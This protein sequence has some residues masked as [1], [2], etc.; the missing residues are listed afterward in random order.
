MKVVVLAGG[1]GG[2]KLAAG[3]AAELAP[4]RVT[5]I[6]NTGDDEEFWGLLVCP[7]VDAVIYRLAGV[8]NEAAGYGQKDETFE[9]LNALARLGEPAWFRIGDRDFATHLLR[10]RL[11]ASGATLT[12]TTLELG[13]RFGVESRVV[14]MTDGRVR[15]RFLTAKGNFS[16]QEYFVRERLQPALEAIAFEGLEAARPSPAAVAALDEADLV[17]IGPSNPLISIDPIVHVVRQVLRRERTIVVSPIVGGSALKGPTVEMMRAVGLEP[18][19]LEVARRYRD[20]ASVF[21]LDEVDR[22]LEPQ[23][24]NLGYEV[25]LART[26][27]D[28]GGRR[29][30]ATLVRSGVR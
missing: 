22:A 19:P 18:S 15:T 23:I 12:E 27:M 20:I 4:S 7:D 29:L 11:I 1:T 2:A 5:V 25:M 10:S 26:V 6:A 14:P 8:F 3:F 9:A 21:V 24:S 28:D 17:V 13:R 16:F 30:A